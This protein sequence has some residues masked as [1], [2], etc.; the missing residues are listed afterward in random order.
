MCA[1]INEMQYR[2]IDVYTSKQISSLILFTNALGIK[3]RS[4]TFS[5][6]LSRKGRESL[7]ESVVPS[8]GKKR[9]KFWIPIRCDAAEDRETDRE[10][11]IQ[12]SLT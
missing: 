11:R 10:S 1:N 6:F 8:V 3:A 9:Q 4:S 5:A 2:L 12:R 7:I